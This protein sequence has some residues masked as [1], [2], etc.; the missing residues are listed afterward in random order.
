ML[1]RVVLTGG[2]AT[3]KSHCLAQFAA[4]G[5][6]VV[7]ADELA[8]QVLE[9]DTPSFNRV[10]ERF[11]EEYVGV[12]NTLDRKRLGSLIFSDE[13]ARRDLEAIVHPAVYAAI[14]AWFARRRRGIAI[15]DIPLLFETGHE[16]EFD[17]VIVAACPP[18]LQ[19]Q[20]LMARDHLPMEDAQRRIA[21]QLPIDD[22]KARAD[23][24]IDTSGTFDE[25]NAQVRGVW[26]RL[27]R[28]TEPA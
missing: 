22:K 20:R 27:R 14:E 11:G 7:D 21:T 16:R 10:I 19:L 13:R 3:G 2:I 23:F 15:A 4:L 26:D 17:R 1:S 5:A 6:V 24:V 28:Q 18:A 12:D 25:T 9:P 8:H